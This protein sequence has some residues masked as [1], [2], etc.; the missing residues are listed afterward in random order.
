[1]ESPRLTVV[2]LADLADNLV[3]SPAVQLIIAQNLEGQAIF[4]LILFYCLEER[5]G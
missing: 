3:H 5:G 1:M 4:N 2:L